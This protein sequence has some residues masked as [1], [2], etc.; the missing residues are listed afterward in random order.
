M[1]NRDGLTFLDYTSFSEDVAGQ[2]DRKKLKLHQQEP[3][4]RRL[5]PDIETAMV[6]ASIAYEHCGLNGRASGQVSL[7]R[8]DG[9]LHRMSIY[10]NRFVAPQG[11]IKLGLDAHWSGIDGAASDT[12]ESIVLTDATSPTDILAMMQAYVAKAKA[13]RPL[14]E[15]N[16]EN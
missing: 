6:E 1:K 12:L 8:L 4:V 16:A 15:A 2:I 10:E 7:V 14:Y 9:F 11:A 13:L 5:L 3:L